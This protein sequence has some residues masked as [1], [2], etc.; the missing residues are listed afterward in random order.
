MKNYKLMKLLKDKKVA[1]A[2]QY[3]DACT[4]KLYLSELSFTALENVIVKYQQNET[5]LVEKVYEDALKKGKGSYSA[6]TNSVDYLGIEV[7]PTVLM[8][9]LTMEI[10]SLLHN[11]FDTFAQWINASL[12][13]EDG[14]PMERVSLTKVA[15]KM[16][17]FTEYT[18]QFI[19][20]VIGLPTSPD[21]QYIADYNNTLKHRRQIYVENKIDILSIKG[22]V[23]VPKFEKDGRPHVKVDALALLRNK[24]DFCVGILNSSKAYIEL[25]YSQANN[26]H[27]THRLYNPKT[28]MFFSSKEDYVALR[29]PINYYHYL[30]V[31]GANI[32]DSYHIML[33]CDKMDGM[34]DESIEFYNSTYPIIMIREEETEKIIGILKPADGEKFSI[35]DERELSYR[36]YTPQTSGY[37]PEMFMAICQDVSFHYYPYLS[38]MTGGY[39]LPEKDKENNRSDNPK[40]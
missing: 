13:A 35:K 21:Y 3:F 28:Y 30:E 20:D 38:D 23:D 4:Y 36:K 16:H 5:T 15:E 9:K 19:S 31:D 18:G 40:E 27:V 29:T 25:F 10:M 6:H 14:I 8:D 26:Q 33:T 12:F 24:I 22:S 34:P 39:E 32:Q 7:D 1:D 11:F 37:E 17:E 2:Y